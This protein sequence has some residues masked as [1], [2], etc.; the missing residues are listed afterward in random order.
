MRV[1]PAVS[2]PIITV[3]EILAHGSFLYTSQEYL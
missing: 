1:D 3:V 2:L